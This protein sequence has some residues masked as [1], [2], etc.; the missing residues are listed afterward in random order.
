MKHFTTDTLTTTHYCGTCGHDTVHS[1]SGK[2]L[3]RC[4]EHEGPEYTQ[5][6]IQAHREREAAEQ[7]K[8]QGRLW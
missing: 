3:G 8:R 7:A 2:R 5:R 6:Q 1:V 4:Q